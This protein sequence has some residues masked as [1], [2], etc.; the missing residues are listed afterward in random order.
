M[1]P[2]PLEFTINGKAFHQ[3]HQVCDPLFEVGINQTQEWTIENWTTE[4]HTFHIH[5][6]PFQAEPA[7]GSAPFYQDN[8]LL[9][10]AQ[11]SDGGE[12]TT[13]T[14][15]KVRMKFL[16]YPGTAVF[17]CHVLFHEDHGMMAAFRINL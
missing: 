17:H 5:V 2:E 8:V 12:V 1:P 10:P 9:P 14:R 6:N 4:I 7:P 16:D 11:A 13:P 3:D 15:V